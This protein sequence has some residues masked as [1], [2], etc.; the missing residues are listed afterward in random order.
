MISTRWTSF[1]GQSGDRYSAKGGLRRSSRKQVLGIES[2]RPV[3]A[4]QGTAFGTA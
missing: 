3:M 2:I 1:K 4:G